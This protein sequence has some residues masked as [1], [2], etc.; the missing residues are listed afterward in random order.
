MDAL[1]FESEAIGFHLTAHPLDAYATTLRR[2]GVVP[3]NQLEQ[4][5]QTGAARVRI[6]G[7][8]VGA[9]ERSTRSGSR[10]AWVRLSDSAGSFEVT[11]FSEVLAR[12]REVLE[13]GRSVLVT[14]DIRMEGEALRVT[15]NDVTSLD[16]AA[17]SVGGAIRI[18]LDRTEAVAHVRA[19]LQREGARSRPRRADPAAWGTGRTWRSR[20]PAASASR[21]GL[22]RR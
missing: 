21:R 3:S 9:K 14:A 22:P 5:A 13:S 4:R 1:A 11:A 20:C 18:W 7:T 15:A 19:L 6:A 10:M 8:V 16:Q 17:S 2:L 12:A